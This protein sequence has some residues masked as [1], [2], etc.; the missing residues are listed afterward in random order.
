MAYRARMKSQM[1]SR[2]P[3]PKIPVELEMDKEEMSKL[4]GDKNMRV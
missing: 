1:R 2:A 3:A 4:T